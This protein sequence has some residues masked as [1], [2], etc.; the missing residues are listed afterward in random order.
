MDMYED[1]E[2][3]PEDFA[4]LN[5]MLNLWVS[6]NSS[7]KE[8]LEGGVLTDSLYSIASLPINAISQIVSLPR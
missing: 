7:L 1:V 2:I 6:N 4:F 5:Q 3:P 8:K